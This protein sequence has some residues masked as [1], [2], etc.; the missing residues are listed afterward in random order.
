LGRDRIGARWEAGKTYKDPRASNYY[1]NEFGRSAANCPIDG[2]WM[3]NWLRSPT[4]RRDDTPERAGVK[5][6]FGE[7]LIVK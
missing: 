7:D 6:F 5:P 4:G 1:K 3:W 2:G